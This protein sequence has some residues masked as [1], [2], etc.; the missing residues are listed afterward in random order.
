MFHAVTGDRKII[1]KRMLKVFFRKGWWNI[2]LFGNFTENKLVI[3]NSSISADTN[4]RFYS[5]V[6]EYFCNFAT[7][8]CSIQ[9][10]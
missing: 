7:L 2:V 8:N 3:S 6:V 10:K 1:T 9:E 4:K 5:L